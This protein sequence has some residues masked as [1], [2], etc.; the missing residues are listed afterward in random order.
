MWIGSAV[1]SSVLSSKVTVVENAHFMVV[2]LAVTT[3]EE[4]VF[5][6][7]DCGS[8]LCGAANRIDGNPVTR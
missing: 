8:Q 2:P 4:P 3:E 1:L 5:V 7:H 6:E